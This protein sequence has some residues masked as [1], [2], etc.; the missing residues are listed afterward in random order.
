MQWNLIRYR[1]TKGKTQ[2]E[3]AELLNI[4]LKTYSNKENGLTQFDMDEMF[5][6]ARYFNVKVDELFTPSSSQ[7]VY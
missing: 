1:K 4:S 3:M 7:K 5:M 2:K 6:L